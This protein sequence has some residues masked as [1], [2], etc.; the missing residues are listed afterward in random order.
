MIVDVSHVSDRTFWDIVNY[1][2]EAGR[3]DAFR[4]SRNRERAPKSDGRHD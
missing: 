2:D 4:M 1:F 3:R